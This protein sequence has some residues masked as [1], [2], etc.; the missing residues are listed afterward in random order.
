VSLTEAGE[1]FLER[2]LPAL[3]TLGEAAEAASAQ[4]GRV[5]G[6]LRLNAPRVVMPLALT[7]IMMDLATEHPRLVVEITT[8]EAVVDIV[9]LGYDA[10]VRLGEMIAEDMV[11]VRLTPSFKSVAVASPAYLEAAGEP[12]TIAEL[13]QH[14]CIA[15]RGRA[16]GAIYAWEM[17]EAGDDVEV[18]VRGTARVS[19]TMCALDLAL[20][21]VGI[22]YLFEP[23]VH[24]YVQNGALRWILPQAA[25]EEP[26]LFLYFPRRASEAPK[27]RA[28]IDA[29][30]RRA[31]KKAAAAT[32]VR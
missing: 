6:V 20:S 8:D 15:Y 31:A 24:D 14:N 10:G 13:Q 28:F 7:E 29:A 1:S 30:R 11:A 12:R 16:S 32:A 9:A 27:L 18:N 2:V 25:I 21:G 17:R 5:T 22:A 19:D 3:E 23:L 4:K 26:G